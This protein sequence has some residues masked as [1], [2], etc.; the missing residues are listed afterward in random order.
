M[1]ER[2]LRPLLRTIPSS[3]SLE[4]DEERTAEALVEVEP[5]L[6]RYRP[7]RER[8]LDLVLVM[9][10]GASMAAWRH[11]VTEFARLLNGLGAFRTISIRLLGTNQETD[12]KLRL[13]GPSPSAPAFDLLTPRCAAAASRHG[14]HG[15]CRGRVAIRFRATAHRTLE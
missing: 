12:G 11:S 14:A 9:D 10:A 3:H 2:A 7:T 1:L 6:P 4:L 5:R 13:R 15:R 8:W